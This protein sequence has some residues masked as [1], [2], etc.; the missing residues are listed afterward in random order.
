[1]VA[2]GRAQTFGNFGPA[3]ASAERLRGRRMPGG[4]RGQAWSILVEFDQTAASMEYPA[5]PAL[6][7]DR[8][9]VDH[10]TANVAAFAARPERA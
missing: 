6:T 4:A 1:M 2:D 8:R 3:R 5:A 7:S 9:S 10:L